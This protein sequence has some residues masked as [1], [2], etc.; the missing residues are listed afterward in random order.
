MTK[1]ILLVMILLC[2][3]SCGVPFKDY[4][5]YRS[6]PDKERMEAVTHYLKKADLDRVPPFI[7]GIIDHALTD[8]SDGAVLAELIPRHDFHRFMQSAV[9]TVYYSL[10]PAY[11]GS[12]PPQL[13]SL[14]DSLIVRRTMAPFEDMDACTRRLRSLIR[15]DLGSGRFPFPVEDTDLTLPFDSAKT[16]SDNYSFMRNIY[17]MNLVSNRYTFE[18]LSLPRNL[19]TRLLGMTLLYLGLNS[20]N[21]T[22]DE[23]IEIADIFKAEWADN[24][25]YYLTSTE[26]AA[27]GRGENMADFVRTYVNT[28]FGRF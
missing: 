6:S 28:V 18:F 19:Q 20:G 26:V 9:P 15:Q 23:L 8:A 21:S 17:I 24:A 16:L 1:T 7:V 14:V 13:A 27:V 5:S 22:V 12:R 25:S 2:A 10:T 4:E 3:M 11:Y